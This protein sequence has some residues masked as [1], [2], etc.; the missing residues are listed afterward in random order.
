MFF[1]NIPLLAEEGWRVAPGWSV[2]PKSMGCRSD[3]PVC[4]FASLGAATPPLRGGE[5]RPRDRPAPW[6][7]VPTAFRICEPVIK[8]VHKTFGKFNFDF[9]SGGALLKGAPKGGRDVASKGNCN[10]WE[11]LCC[12]PVV[13]DSGVWSEHSGD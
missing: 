11:C 1:N 7:H 10:L 4:A 13:R 8:F 6:Q 5:W 2:R 9:E 3:H 12:G